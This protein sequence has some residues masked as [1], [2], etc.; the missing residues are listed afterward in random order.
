MPGWIGQSLGKK[1]PTVEAGYH[2]VPI[3]LVAADVAMP[4]V[5]L[6][7][8]VPFGWIHDDESAVKLPAPGTVRLSLAGLCG[9]AERGVELRI[10]PV[11]SSPSSVQVV[12]VEA[13]AHQRCGQAKTHP[14]EAGFASIQVR[15]SFFRREL[16]WLEGRLDPAAA[17][18]YSDVWL[19]RRLGPVQVL[20]QHV[21]PGHAAVEDGVDVIFQIDSIELVVGIRTGLVGHEDRLGADQFT[22]AA[23]QGRLGIR[24]DFL[25]FFAV[26]IYAVCVEVDGVRISRGNFTGPGV[27]V[28]AQAVDED[29]VVANLPDRGHRLVREPVNDAGGRHV[30]HVGAGP[31]RDWLPVGLQK[32]RHDLAGLSCGEGL[33]RRRDVRVRRTA[34]KMKGDEMWVDFLEFLQLRAKHLAVR[35][36]SLPSLDTDQEVV[37][38]RFFQ[39]AIVTV[40]S[41]AVL[42][43]RRA[44]D[45]GD[46][47]EGWAR[48]RL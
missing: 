6:D 39:C 32:P 21:L 11:L 35:V 40:E 10:P 5:Q 25:Q 37:P 24:P 15:H 23:S 42:G 36:V 4:P 22:R 7:G 33:F 47:R 18:Q 9:I 2:E 46:S 31:T 29:A 44:V 34:R 16:E 3:D 1:D 41:C 48:R 20:L 13:V 26:V 14:L 27:E 12:A 19:P 38:R 43:E 17:S 45:I 8:S 28:R 30:Q